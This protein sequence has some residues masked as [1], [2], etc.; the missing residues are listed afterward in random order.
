MKEEK[1]VNDFFKLPIY[2]NKAKVKL[3]D[4]IITDLELCDSINNDPTAKP[5]YNYLFNTQNDNNDISKTLTEQVATHYTTDVAYLKDTQQIIRE[6]KTLNN[7]TYKQVMPIKELWDELKI[8]NGFKEKYYYVDWQ[9]IEFLN[10]NEIFLQYLSLYNLFSPILSLITPIIILIIP[11]FI[12]RMRGINL[13]ISEYI[14]VLKLVAQTNA[15][16]KLFTVNYSEITTQQSMYIF[17]SAV[18]YVYSIYQNI[19]VCVKFNKNMS[20]IHSYFKD[21]KLYLTPTILSMENYLT[22]SANLTSQ[23]DFNEVLKIKINTLKML[24]DKLQ[25]ISEYSL[26]NISKLKE[27]GNILKLFYELHTDKIYNDAIMYSLGFHTYINFIEGLQTNIKERKV[28][29]A[30]FNKKDKKDKKDTKDKN[31]KNKNIFHKSYYAVL[32][33]DNPIKNTIKMKKNIIITGPNASGKTTII[34][35]TLI[36]I[37]FTQQFGVGFYNLAKLTPFNHIHCYLNIPDTCG[38]DSLFQAEARRCKKILDAITE[39]PSDETHFCMFDELY[40]GTNPEEAEQSAVAFMNYLTKYNN[41]SCLL[42][43]HFI[44]VCKKLQQNKNILNFHMVTE[45]TNNLLN[46]KYILKQGITEIK[47]GINVLTQLNYPKE[48]INNSLVN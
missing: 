42:T 19:N 24:N 33:D 30:E 45:K 28:N 36:N 22:Y 35:S 11:F 2:Y 17:V 20:Q 25:N 31:K 16:G 23:N 15:I 37:I 3:A 47:G 39:A 1:N 29:F 18:F 4:N 41:V 32:K 7:D 27:I 48:I 8:T 6:Y 46:Y 44:N 12:L 5:L 43:T 13:S 10:K 21:L 40:S 26:F 34:K 38:R 14:R 9:A